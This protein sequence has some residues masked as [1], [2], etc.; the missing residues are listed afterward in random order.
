MLPRGIKGRALFGGNR[1][2]EIERFMGK[3]IP[4]SGSWFLNTL[5]EG[6]LAFKKCSLISGEILFASL[7][8][9]IPQ[10]IRSKS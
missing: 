10:Y 1:L 8:K 7:C 3:V 5:L 6:E 9:S 4:G 2:F